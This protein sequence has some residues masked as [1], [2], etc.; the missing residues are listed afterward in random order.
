MRNKTYK[1]TKW[2]DNKTCVNA[3]NLNKIED[4]LETLYSEALSR[5]QIVGGDGIVLDTDDEGRAVVSLDESS[6][7]KAVKSGTVVGMEYTSVVPGEPKQN[8]LY[9]I[10][11]PATGTLSK[12]MINGA[13]IFEI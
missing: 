4:A 7:V 1:K 12:I 8:T 2:V 6:E 9:F 5:D 3:Y 13:A 10:I 11:D